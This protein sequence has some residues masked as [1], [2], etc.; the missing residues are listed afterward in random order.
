MIQ[1]GKI[2][3]YLLWEDQES[4]WSFIHAVC[5]NPCQVG[6]KNQMGWSVEWIQTDL[7][8]L[9]ITRR[10]VQTRLNI[11]IHHL[12]TGRKSQP[13]LTNSAA[14]WSKR[15]QNQLRPQLTP[16][17]ASHWQV[18]LRV[19]YLKWTTQPLAQLLLFILCLTLRFLLLLFLP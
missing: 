9:K 1:K 13:R 18:S 19:R 12:K 4:T 16:F 3:V 8:D 14:S 17:H 2:W 5:L 11:Q 6:L 10:G 7:F 15:Q